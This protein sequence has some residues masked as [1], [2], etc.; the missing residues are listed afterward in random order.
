[1]WAHAGISGLLSGY[2]A[3]HRHLEFEVVYYVKSPDYGQFMDIQ[4]RINLELI[5]RFQAS[6]IEFAFPTQTI[7]LATSADGMQ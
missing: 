2:L 6:G 3:R 1:M 5:S 7:H 4:Q